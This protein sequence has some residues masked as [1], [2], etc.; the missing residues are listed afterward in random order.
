MYHFHVKN[1]YIKMSVWTISE[2][3]RKTP[4]IGLALRRGQGALKVLVKISLTFI[5][6]CKQSHSG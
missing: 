6:L 4:V 1:A 5:S 3:K 2:R